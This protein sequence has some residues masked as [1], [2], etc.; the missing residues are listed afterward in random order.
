MRV[1]GLQ[2][3]SHKSA[4]NRSVASLVDRLGGEYQLRDQYVSPG[5][6]LVVQWGFKPTRGL[7]AAI[8]QGIP[9]VIL[10]LGYIDD[11]RTSRFSVSLN[12]FHGLAMRDPKVLDRPPRPAPGYYDWKGDG[13]RVYVIGQ[14]PNDQ[15]LRGQDIDAWMGRTA[16]AASEVWGL[17]VV[18][19][20][21]PKMLNPW[22]PQPEPLDEVF[23]DAHVVITWTSTTAVQSVLAG[24]PT[25]A[26]H[27]GNM[28]YPICASDLRIVRS[29]ARVGW[30]H[31]L[32]WREW[33]FAS[34][35]DLDSLAEYIIEML[36]EMKKCE[37]D[38]PRRRL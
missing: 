11:G 23:K 26:M 24:V 38:T 22:E 28:A 17:P 25:I 37:Q 12:G 31:E 14:M 27:P 4:A 3:E 15:S 8:A 2:R 36:P 10:D 33:D 30:I 21:H 13:E 9:Y 7:M 35:T 18:K 6:D 19:R 20:P 29:P 1:L 5:T 16:S 32:S 34:D